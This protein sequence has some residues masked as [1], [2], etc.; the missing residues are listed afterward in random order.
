MLGR[1]HALSGLVTGAA[2]GEFALHLQ[3][4]GTAALAAL[5]AGFATV[6][7]LDTCHSCAARSLG[8]M[9]EAFAWTVA[10][11]SGGHRHGTH[12]AVGVAVFT[13]LAWAAC[14]YR[15][16]AA[17][18]IALGAFL[19]LAIAAGLRA[20]RLGGHGADLAAIAAAAG[21][22]YYGWALALIP[23]ACGLGC[24]THLAGDA[25]TDEGIPLLWPITLKH[26]R[27]WPEPLAFSTGTR[28]ETLIVAP[29]LLLA[30]GWL[31]WHAVTLTGYLT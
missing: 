28:P 30:S 25:L 7:D 5:C 24:A 2:A 21:I 10:K 9:S 12:S 22:A 17:G 14:H 4:P 1:S 16:E 19:A 29:A 26:Y 15:A 20:L 3:P 8:F 11:L 23:L 13:A 18:R 31:A 6:P 27:L